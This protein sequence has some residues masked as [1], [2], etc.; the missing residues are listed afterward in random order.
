MKITALE[1][2][3]LEEFANLLWLR[4]HTDEGLVGLGETFFCRDTVEAYVHEA[5]APKL[6]GR[7]PLADR[8]DRQGPHRLCGLSFDRRGDARQLGSSTSRSG[9]SS[10]R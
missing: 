1:T 7:D 5:V 8:P 4:V 2:I 3:R 6:L 9:T 10:A